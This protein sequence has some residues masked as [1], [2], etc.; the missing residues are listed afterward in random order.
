MRPGPEGPLE[1]VVTPDGRGWVDQWPVTV[2]AGSD[3]RV[4]AAELLSALAQRERCDISAVLVETGRNERWRMLFRAG[5]EILQSARP[6]RQPDG[7]AETGDAAAR[8]GDD[9]DG[10][11]GDYAAGQYEDEENEHAGDIESWH[12]E[13]L[14]ADSASAPS[15][16]RHATPEWPSGRDDDTNLMATPGPP[17]DVNPDSVPAWPHFDITL[18]S[19]QHVV[20]N[21]V[22][23]VIPRAASDPRAYGVAIA[24]A[25]LRRMGLARPV[26]AFARDPDG[27]IW[28]ILIHPSGAATEAGPPEVHGEKSRRGNRRAER[29][30]FH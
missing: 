2:P 4:V 28:P 18:V 15:Q 14:D 13:H 24:A 29:R 19:E 22:R 6:L 30:A 16:R 23:H 26:R 20:V 7:P 10:W 3:P 25:Q 11:Q 27:T 5:G 21:G 9:A 12:E 8:H 1:I 17:L